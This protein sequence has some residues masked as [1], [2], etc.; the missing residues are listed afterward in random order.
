MSY[1]NPEQERVTFTNA[2]RA[3]KLMEGA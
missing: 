1:R 3:S 2:E